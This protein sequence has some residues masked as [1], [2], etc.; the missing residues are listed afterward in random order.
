MSSSDA[1]VVGISPENEQPIVKKLGNEAD[2]VIKNPTDGPGT[3]PFS[4]SL[5]MISTVA[6]LKKELNSRYPGSPP[7]RAQ[8]LIYAGKL[9]RDGQ[10]FCE[11]LSPLQQP[12]TPHTIHLVVSSP[13]QARQS[14]QNAPSPNP[15]SSPASTSADGGAAGPQAPRLPQFAYN[16]HFLGGQVPLPLQEALYAQHLQI[17]ESLLARTFQ[18]GTGAQSDPRM[19]AQMHAAD[20]AAAA[21]ATNTPEGGAQPY[22]MPPPLAPGNGVFPGMMPMHPDVN[23]QNMPH[24]NMAAAQHT[25]AH[26][27]PLPQNQQQNGQ[28]HHHQPQQPRAF[29]GFQLDVQI[30]RHGV[31]NRIRN[32]LNAQNQPHV[33]QFVFQIEINW[34]LMAKLI[35]LVYLLGYEGNSSRLF[36]LIIVAVGI[37]LWQTGHLGWLRRIVY[38][39]L[40]SPGRLIENLFPPRTQQPDTQQE[41]ASQQSPPA[42]QNPYGYPALIFSFVYSFL[43]GFVCSL[44]PAWNPQPLPRIE[45]IVQN[46]ERPQ[47]EPNMGANHDHVD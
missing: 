42:R 27:R 14:S 15:V 17:V 36:S 25:Q 47:E 37:Y 13:Q 7:I 41:D 9:L 44:L 22:A 24:M 12:G 3:L 35:F 31:P 34:A 32:A 26:Q 21:A 19:L 16:G 2:V 11:F 30:G 8:R 33:R 29:N 10:K 38:T 20:I 23:V 46:P 28:P 4:L 6:E 45:Q 1:P 5:P 43:Y 18:N 40:P 39:A